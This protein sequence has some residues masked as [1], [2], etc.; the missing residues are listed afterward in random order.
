[1]GQVMQNFLY[2][3]AHRFW[4]L[5]VWVT[6]QEKIRNFCDYRFADWLWLRKVGEAQKP[7]IKVS[8][9]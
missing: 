9:K 1:M 3:I 4:N 6:Y 8:I 2:F 5:Q 7:M